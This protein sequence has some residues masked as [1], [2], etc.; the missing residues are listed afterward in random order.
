M[1]VIPGLNVHSDVSS[2]PARLLP[3]P[4][5]EGTGI[6]KWLEYLFHEE[7]ESWDHSAWG[8]ESCKGM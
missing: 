7:R 8:K 1:E 4:S 6:I 2:F 5:E 3:P